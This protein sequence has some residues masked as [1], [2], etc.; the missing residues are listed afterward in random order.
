MAIK[1]KPQLPK[2]LKKI[3]DFERLPLVLFLSGPVLL[4]ILVELL[5]HNLPWWHLSPLQAMLNIALYL[6]AYYIVYLLLGRL[7]LTAGIC[8]IFF[9]IVGTVNHYVYEFRGRTLFP[10]DFAS[11]KTAFNVAG[12]YDYTPSA[13]QV[14]TALILCAYLLLLIFTP[15]VRGRSLPALRSFIT[16][17]SMCLMFFVVFF[18]TGAVEAIGI[19]PSLWATRGNGLLL[20]F[21]LSLKCSIGNKP[22]DYSSEEVA[23]LAAEYPSD[24]A[25]AASPPNIIAIMNESFADL[26]VV[27]DFETNAET[28]PF[29]NSLI[30][31]TLSGYAYSSVFGG[32]TA[33]AEY[34]FLTGNTIAFLP[35]G[36]VPYQLYIDER[37]PA[38]PSQLRSLGYDTLALH[39]YDSSGWNRIPVYVNL[40]FNNAMFIEDFRKPKYMRNYLTDS[41]NYENLIRIFEEKMQDD[42][43]VFMFNITMQNHSAY[44]V[45]YNGLPKTV[46]L[47]GELAGEY[48]TVDQYLSLM[49][50]SDDALQYLIEYF[51]DIEEPTAILLFGDHMPQVS[52]DFYENMLGS[53]LREL[54]AETLQK[55]QMTPYFIWANFPLVDREADAVSMNYLSALLL[56]TLDLPLTGYQQFQLELMKALPVVNT[57]GFI[58]SDGIHTASQNELDPER[59]DLLHRYEVLEYC[60]VFDSDNRP[61]DFYFLSD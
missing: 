42:A 61:K 44:D 5:N 56:E 40:G 54:P 53:R 60:D 49:R 59:A 52:N 7:K 32:T 31:D 2:T 4:Y 35:E 6:S 43:P 41:S 18:V 37:T 22:D 30:D 15:R 8:S 33:N 23:R 51:E 34:E 58:D 26:S 13:I 12:S 16:S 17:T 24:T 19:E 10:T 1:T 47:E 9:Y 27:G 38:L 50:E 14:V 36:S 48:P 46:R 57:V 28:M 29:F 39:P 20:N 3:R 11:I 21:S 45:P 25:D 55:R